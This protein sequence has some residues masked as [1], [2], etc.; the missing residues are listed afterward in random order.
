[1]AVESRVPTK[2]CVARRFRRRRWRLTRSQRDA[3]RLRRP[4]AHRFLTWTTTV[5]RPS[6]DSSSPKPSTS[7]VPMLGQRSPKWF[8]NTLPWLGQTSSSLHK[9]ALLVWRPM[10]STQC[11]GCTLVMQSNIY[12][13][14]ARRIP[15][16]VR[17]ICLT[18]AIPCSTSQP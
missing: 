12:S 18:Q 6:N 1:M 4:A 10:R 9:L 2:A 13:S 15:R 16:M 17:L 7:T 5:C 3:Q 11:F 14:H 8:Q